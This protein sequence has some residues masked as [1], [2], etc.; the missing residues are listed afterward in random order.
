MVGSYVISRVRLQGT[1][2]LNR[3]RETDRMARESVKEYETVMTLSVSTT[4]EAALGGEPPQ[5]EV[6]GRLAHVNVCGR[7][8]TC[9]RY[10][11]FWT[12]V[13]GHRERSVDFLSTRRRRGRDLAPSLGRAS[14]SSYCIESLSLSR[15][16]RSSL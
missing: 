12:E 3:P 4:D 16:T 7:V 8:S 14:R 1:G 5:R 10:Q 15:L 2:I 6:A 9:V 13:E 11:P